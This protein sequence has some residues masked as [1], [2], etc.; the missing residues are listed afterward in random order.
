MSLLPNI[1][2]LAGALATKTPSAFMFFS[3]FQ[4]ILHAKRYKS[5]QENWDEISGQGASKKISGTNAQKR[6]E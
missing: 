3:F 6:S 1:G 4:Q 2:F 5:T